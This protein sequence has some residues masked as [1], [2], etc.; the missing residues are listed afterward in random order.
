MKPLKLLCILSG[1]DYAIISKCDRSVQFRFAIIGTFVFFIFIICFASS[2]LTF[3]RLFQSIVLGVPFSLFFAWMITN[4]YLLLL[5]TLTRSSL[6]RRESP[7]A[8]FF[9]IGVRIAFICFIAIMVSKPVELLIYEGPLKKDV[10]NYKRDL[11]TSYTKK[12]DTLLA[13]QSASIVAGADGPNELTVARREYLLASMSATVAKSNFYIQR[14]II[15]N[16]NYPSCWVVTLLGVLIFIAPGF[17]KT[18]LIS[19]ALFAMK[20][21]IE[22]SLVVREYKQFRSVHSE[23]TLANVKLDFKGSLFDAEPFRQKMLSD[24][25]EARYKFLADHQEHFQDPP[26]NTIKIED[27]RVFGKEDILIEMLYNG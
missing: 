14:I 16:N 18:R 25:F 2:I 23:I 4:L 24:K 8:N 6:P 11:L 7:V 20:K 27:N 12:V 3:T 17:V 22:V 5:Y 15:L 9:S 21:D 19:E 10:E 1:D 26:F 13:N